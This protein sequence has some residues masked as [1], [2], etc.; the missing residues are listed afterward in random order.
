MIVRRRGRN[1]HNE[2]KHKRKTLTTSAGF[3][4]AIPTIERPQTYTLDRMAAGI[5]RCYYLL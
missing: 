4:Q 1:L 2:K 3:E 5:G